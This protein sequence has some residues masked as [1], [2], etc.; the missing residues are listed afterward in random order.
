MK[1]DAGSSFELL[2][3]GIAA[4]KGADGLVQ[5]V[6]AD[7][8]SIDSGSAVLAGAD[9]DNST[10]TPVP[11]LTGAGADAV[12]TSGHELLIAGTVTTADR[13]ALTAG[14]AAADNG[15][16]F[17][18]LPT[19][20]YLAPEHAYS[21]L[22]SGT[23][24]TLASGSHLALAAPDAVLLRGN[25]NV[26]GA[27]SDLTVRSDKWVYVEGF[28]NVDAGV[29]LYGGYDSNLATTGGANGRKASVYLDKTARVT[30]AR[31]GSAHPGRGGR[32]RN[33]P[34]RRGGRRLDRQRRGDVRR[35][36]LGR[37]RDGGPAG[38]HQRLRS[39]PPTPSRSTAARRAAASPAS[40]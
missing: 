6:A 12:I 21:I 25:V 22:M 16:Y 38:L 9:F 15:A 1:I 19:T 37:D 28:L 23:L 26:A 10:G 14:S 40:T 13:M 8:V 39:T 34:R 2:Q 33:R 35:G 36:R 11:V 17:A 7:S 29:N 18:A 27:G 5:I 31:A 20:S 24:T 4:A 30:T 3:G 32:G